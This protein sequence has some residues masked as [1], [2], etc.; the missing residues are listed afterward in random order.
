M[1]IVAVKAAFLCLA[2]AL[3]IAIAHVNGD[4]MYASY[5]QGNCIKKP[6]EDLLKA[7]GVD[8]CKGGSLQ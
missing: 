2:R 8:L 3:N 6:V 7:S 1:S 4:P 5:R